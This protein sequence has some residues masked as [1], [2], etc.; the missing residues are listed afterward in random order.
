MCENFHYT[1]NKIASSII[2][3]LETIVM[4]LLVEICLGIHWIKFG[5]WKSAQ[6]IEYK[7]FTDY[8]IM[9]SLLP[10]RQRTKDKMTAM[11]RRNVSLLMLT[12]KTV[13]SFLRDWV[14]GETLNSF[15]LD[16][17]LT[18]FIVCRFSL[19]PNLKSD[20]L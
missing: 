14:S 9:A 17:I 13:I 19:N 18:H 5:W 6:P 20:S 1:I 15:L 3:L 7:V 16:G 2:L 12:G 8:V 11:K 10:K 4:L